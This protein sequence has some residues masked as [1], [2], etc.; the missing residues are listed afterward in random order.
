MDTPLFTCAYSTIELFIF[1][2]KKIRNKLKAKSNINN[3]NLKKNSFFDIE[4]KIKLTTACVKCN[5]LKYLAIIKKKI[6][7]NIN[8]ITC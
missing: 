4:Q 3:N 5:H 8:N 1:E 2:K 7:K 6:E